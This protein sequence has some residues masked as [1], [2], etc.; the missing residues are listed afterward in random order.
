M[1]HFPELSGTLGAGS[2]RHPIGREDCS[3]GGQG[4][5][6]PEWMS[7]GSGE[8][9][10]RRPKPVL[11]ERSQTWPLFYTLLLPDWKVSEVPWPL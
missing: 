7:R 9:R 1:S 3:C 5:G 11:K 8:K 2:H 4:T 10:G 6:P